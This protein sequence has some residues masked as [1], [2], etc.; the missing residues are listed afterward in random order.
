MD[1][2]RRLWLRTVA[3][4][5]LAASAA[6][7]FSL[8]LLGAVASTGFIRLHPMLL[9][10]PFLV[11]GWY[12]LFDGLA[13][14]AMSTPAG[15]LRGF[16]LTVVA[17]Y[18]VASLTAPG[19]LVA[20]FYPNVVNVGSEL[21]LVLTWIIASTLR[22][23][24]RA[25]EELAAVTGLARPQEIR[26]I[27][28]ESAP[29]SAE[30]AQQLR[31]IRTILLALGA[32]LLVLI[33]T[34]HAA[35]LQLSW[36]LVPATSGFA[37]SAALLIGLV[38][39]GLEE[40]NL[41]GDGIFVPSRYRRRRFRSMLI[42]TGAILIPILLLSRNRSILSLQMIV[43]LFQFLASLFERRED[44]VRDAMRPT[45]PPTGQRPIPEESIFDQLGEHEPSEFLLALMRI[46]ERLFILLVAGGVLAFLFG[47]LFGRAFR[48]DIRQLRPLKRLL[49]GL[50]DML[51]RGGRFLR[52]L[53]DG[54]RSFLGLAKSAAE[55]AR[56]L[57]P[58]F[59]FNDDRL[60]PELRK[61]KRVEWDRLSRVYLRAV[62]WADERGVVLR[63]SDTPREFAVR[64]IASFDTAATW[65]GDAGQAWWAATDTVERS[66]YSAALLTEEDFARFEADVERLRGY[67]QKK[68]GG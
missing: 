63:G 61:R 6:I 31:A 1:Q 32:F 7:T 67:D 21:L 10:T 20:R 62:A 54:L 28:T 42:L 27:V 33:A 25:R 18:L 53:V 64:V 19:S 34:A 15:R 49:S 60:P 41:R 4:P 37:L 65:A 36:V 16:A 58:M 24:L 43:R 52:L 2:H 8:G 46:L 30:T 48:K 55:G 29:L 14:D 39:V 22:T 56:R 40:L 23:R 5:T 47:P 38:R 44:P 13:T 17:L 45:P 11:A 66:L 50:A 68:R 35:G 59:R 12:I 57:G 51:S 9:A 3:H 26:H